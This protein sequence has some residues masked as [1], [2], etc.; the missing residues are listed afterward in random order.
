LQ[1]P[2]TAARAHLRNLA[3]PRGGIRPRDDEH[4]LVAEARA[5]RPCS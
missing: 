3:P 2:V 1:L 5:A 4:T